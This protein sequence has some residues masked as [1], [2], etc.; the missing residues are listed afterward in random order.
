M[1]D[2]KFAFRQLLKN[3]GFTAVAV[4]TLALGIGANTAI[5][6]VINAV[7]LRP[8]PFPNPERLFWI[9]EVSK[10]GSQEPWGGHFLDWREHSQTLEQVAAYDGGTRTLTG[11]GEPERVEVGQASADL[12]SLLGVQ[13]VAPGRGFSSA[14]DKP[15]GDPV[16]I[17]SQSLWQ[18]R[19]NRAQDIVGRSITLND[20]SFTII[21]VLPASFQFFQQFDVWVPLALD[22]QKELTSDT[23]Y[24]GP[25]LVRLKPGVS[26]DKARAELDTLLQRYEAGR[27]DGKPRFADYRTQFVPLRDHLLGDAR[28]PLLVLL[29]AVGL[30]LLI[31]CANVANLLL[32]R[33]VTRQKE[34]AIRAA[35]GAS[36]FRL[37]CQ[38]LTE[39]LLLASTGGLAGLLFAHW[40][41]TL[42]HSL[43]LADV[44]GPMA[45]VTVINVDPR[46]FIFA[47]LLSLATGIVFGL[48]PTFRVSQPNLDS[49]LR[50]GARGSK[51][52]GKGLRG[53]LLVGEVAIAIVLLAGA[54]LLL[55]SFAKLIGV[56]PGYRPGNLLTAQLRLPPRYDSGSKRAQFY[57]QSL[58]RAAA[59]PGVES[60]GATS[61]LPLTRY[62]MGGTLRVKDAAEESGKRE[63]AAPISAVNA[64]YF[65]TMGIGLRT[66]RLFNDG[67]TPDTA[68]VVLLSET[69][70]RTLFPDGDPIGERIFVAG[71]GAEQA[72]VIGVVDD[73]RHQG[74]DR[75]IEPA[76]YLS[77]R[78]LPRPMMSLVL[79]TRVAPS[80]LV[81]S[82]RAAVGE[83]DPALPVFDVMTMDARLSNSFAGRRFNLLLL[84]S[85]AALA[86]LLAGVGVYGVI[87]YL[88]SER[89]REVGI[90]MA[91]GAGRGEV[92]AL[93]LRHAMKLAS[94]GI[95]IGV[96]AAFGLTRLMTTLLFEVRPGDPITFVAVSATLLLV[97]LAASWLPARRASRVDPVEA[98]RSE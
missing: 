35:L 42:F 81:R 3:P 76:A 2:I 1:N 43:N 10:K 85:F 22:G 78:Q 45:L 56:D 98:L 64:D 41:V 26:L 28:R 19:Y 32:A 83:V 52:Q 84:G 51:S 9:E 79:R 61:Q 33:A 58:Q 68:S 66:G 44:L 29:G 20:V 55:R 50:E 27:P 8:L 88:V 69:L 48:L 21:G 16:A 57:E 97:A 94:I 70:A 75:A 14:E 60:V 72:T 40:L 74:L 91:L 13:P 87:A 53:A 36:Q 11:A 86:L 15:G 49:S 47:L 18:H 67:D 23:H 77:Y 59:L 90:R 17:L 46:V 65:R 25:T 80:S 89:T 7:M 96:S 92:V 39:C 93:V 4:L 37:T 38:T 73:I 63:T 5:F 12:L 31:A 24:Y 30:I 95:V 82:L 34:L 54:G 71:S 6:S 62:N